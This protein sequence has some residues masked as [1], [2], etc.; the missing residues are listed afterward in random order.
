MN[1]QNT[2]EWIEKHK[3]TL[4]Y[5]QIFELINNLNHVWSRGKVLLEQEEQLRQMLK[6]I[7]LAK[8]H[9]F[10]LDEQESLFLLL[11]YLLIPNELVENEDLW[12]SLIDQRQAFSYFFMRLIF[13]GRSERVL[14][15]VFEDC[16]LEQPSGQKKKKFEGD[17]SQL[18][19]LLPY[20]LKKIQVN[21]ISREIQYYLSHCGNSKS[22]YEFLS[23]WIHSHAADQINS[24]IW[25]VAKVFIRNA[26]VYQLENLLPV[27]NSWFQDADLRKYYLAVSAFFLIDK[28]ENQ[29]VLIQELLNTQVP[30]RK[31]LILY[32]AR[33]ERFVYRQLWLEAFHSRQ[34]YLQQQASQILVAIKYKAYSRDKWY[35]PPFPNDA[36]LWFHLWK[37]V[38][39]PAV[40]LN[41]A[42]E[43]FRAEPDNTLV[44]DWLVQQMETVSAKRVAKI[45]TC[46]RETASPDFCL[47]LAL[48][49]L[50]SPRPLLR[51]QAAKQLAA[52]PASE[53]THQ[54][55]LGALR[56]RAV[57]VQIQA[58]KALAVQAPE[59]VAF[60][61]WLKAQLSEN[62]DFRIAEALK[63]IARLKRIE[64]LPLLQTMRFAHSPRL[65]A[66][67]QRTLARLTA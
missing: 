16:F 28:P 21:P 37:E 55:L 10:T 52:L 15:K 35:L 45:W 2:I 18:N 47:E 4:V 43:L 48:L 11:D 13:K 51:E 8:I 27:W 25:D 1:H 23:T 59:S 54:A 32:F 24:Q 17:A 38:D 60:N 64:M 42:C 9:T 33:Q 34:P 36:A 6:E 3:E 63:L 22:L 5:E 12:L 58:A 19:L 20:Y 65:Q 62:E 40:Q 14:K 26:S 39:C 56:D 53:T 44:R 41:G 57:P 67:L 61:N 46:L 31:A 7:T 50:D 30:V 49:H 29:P 66:C